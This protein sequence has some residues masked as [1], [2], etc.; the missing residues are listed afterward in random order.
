VAKNYLGDAALLEIEV[1]GVSVVVKLP[2]DEDLQVGQHALL[3]LPSN[4][5]QVYT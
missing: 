5:W 4:R 2:G 1:N 3:I